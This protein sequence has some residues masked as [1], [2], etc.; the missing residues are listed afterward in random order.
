MPKI[1]T[2]YK[3]LYTSKK[4]Y[5]ILTG[6]RGSGKTFGVMD[7][8]IRLMEEVG[9]G[10]LFTRYTMVSMDKTIIPLFTSYISQVADINNYNITKKG[11]IN[12][13]TGSFIM[14]S[15]IKTSS[16]DQTGNLKSLPNITTWVIEEGEDYNDEDS[17]TDIDDSIRSDKTQNRVIWIQNPSTQEHFIYQKFFKES[18]TLKTVNGFTY[19]SSTHEDVE[20]IHT[21]YLDNLE[22]L[23]K[24]KVEQWEK[25]KESNPKKYQHKYI[26][27]WLDKAE[28]VIFENWVEGEF[29]T[30]LPYG[31]GQ[32]Y[33]FSVDPTT[34]VKLAVDKNNK[35]CYWHE[36]YYSDKS[37]GTNGIYDVNINNID[38]PNDLIVGDS[39]EDRLIFDLKRLGLN[40][41]KCEK[42]SGSIKAGI[43]SMED[44]Q[45]IITPTS[46]N[47]KKEFNNY[48]WND[49][50]SGIPID[51]YNH[52]M[53]AGRYIFRKLTK[54]SGTWGS[55]KI[56]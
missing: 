34:L 12:K 33:G 13:R 48:I 9:Q 30:S 29:D 56:V 47:I 54:N 14:F 19:Q 4:R 37:L 46:H 28:G 7:L 31:Y 24:R 1:K 21:T 41:I 55:S 25:L 45:H 22:N 49:K 40:I 15:G 10:I 35:K 43:T 44:Y 42:G 50:K 18:Y 52:A 6:G 17:F 27:A 2:K 36:A 53:D 3:P 26:G 20:H 8:V 5:F 51:D 39:S 11:I 16:G 23:D 38:N 32:D